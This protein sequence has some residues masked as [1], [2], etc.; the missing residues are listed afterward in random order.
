M[1]C[2]PIPCVPGTITV[3]EYFVDQVRCNWY[4]I[5]VVRV[6]VGTNRSS[7]VSTLLVPGKCVLWYVYLLSL[8]CSFAPQNKKLLSDEEVTSNVHFVLNSA[9][10]TFNTTPT[11]WQKYEHKIKIPAHLLLFAT[12]VV[13]S[14]LVSMC[15]QDRCVDTCRYGASGYSIVQNF[16]SYFCHPGGT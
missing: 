9:T 5:Q 12:E 3:S 4:V 7:V 2:S 6:L 8:R 1:E 13:F 10:C 15:V 16:P 14:I 11:R